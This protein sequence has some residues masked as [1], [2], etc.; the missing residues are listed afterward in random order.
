[1]S[2]KQVGLEIQYWG[3]LLLLVAILAFCMEAAPDISIVFWTITA[4]IGVGAIRL[5]HEQRVRAG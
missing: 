5:N 1:M 3:E 2:L 4:L